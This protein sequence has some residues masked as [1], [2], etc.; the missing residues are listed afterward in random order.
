M[1]ALGGGQVLL[2][3]RAVVDVDRA[4]RAVVDTSRRLDG[5]VP[6]PRLVALLA[7]LDVEAAAALA[8]VGHVG[9]P[10]ET[11]L[12]GLNQQVLTTTEVAQ[13]MRL[14]ERT[15]RRRAVEF[16]GRKGS[17]GWQFDGVAVAAARADWQAAA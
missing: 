11:D 16:G 13:M 10:P 1:I 2:R 8:E 15:V 4:V 6:P 17:S 5:I 9:R 3:G 14:S 12:P 7:V